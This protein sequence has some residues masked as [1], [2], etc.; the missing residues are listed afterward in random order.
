MRFRRLVLAL[1]VLAL[2][3]PALGVS[4]TGTTTVSGV[5]GSELSVSTTAAAAMTLTH[6]TPG[7][8][9]TTVTVTSTLPTWA[10]TVSDASATTPGKMDK[11]DCV[12]RVLLG[13]SLTNALAWS[14][15]VEGTSGSLSATPATVKSNGALVGSVAV[16]FTQSL[17]A[18][19]GAASGSCYELTATWTAT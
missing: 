13:G 1:A 5:V 2:A 11:V 15:P 4:A 8:S 9:S 6:A 18:G 14:A 7:S 12:T 10:L 16:N 19:D 3:Q 17:A